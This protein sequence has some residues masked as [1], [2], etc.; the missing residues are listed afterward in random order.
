V[1]H[2]SSSRVP[3]PDMRSAEIQ[4]DS[5]RATWGRDE[6]PGDR[7]PIRRDATRPTPPPPPGETSDVLRRRLAEEIDY[8]RRM[9]AAMGDELSSDPTMVARHGNALQSVDLVGQLLGHVASVVRAADADEAV[10]R[11]G[12]GELKA[13]LQRRGGL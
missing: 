10:Q 2:N 13:R 12:M 3:L 4:G 7:K 9:L 6:E 11:I 5:V 1:P 8:A